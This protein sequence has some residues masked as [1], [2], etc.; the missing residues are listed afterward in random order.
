MLRFIPVSIVDDRYKWMANFWSYAQK[1]IYGQEAFNNSIL[2]V[3]KQNTTKDKIY[4][5]IDWKLHGLPYHMCPPIWKYVKSKNDNCVVIN[6]FSAIKPII[7]NFPDED[8]IVLSDM[9]VVMLKKYDNVLPG[10]DNVICYDGYEDW[11]MFIAN[12]SKKNYYKIQPYLHHNDE[13]YMNGG[14]IPIFIKNKTLKKIIDDVINIAEKIIESDCDPLWKWWSCMTAFSIVC[15][16]HKIKMISQDNTYIPSHNDY[17][18]QNHY[19]VHYSVDK[20][21]NKATFP[22]HD[23]S[24]Y[25]HTNFYNLVRDWIQN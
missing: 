22:N 23:I 14:F 10:D 4:N 5:D 21:F 18:I 12:S 1:K 9:D 24:S 13:G 16:N 25:P 15:H 2:S 6:V 7:K 3:V 11:H 8:I 20:V 17:N 19:F